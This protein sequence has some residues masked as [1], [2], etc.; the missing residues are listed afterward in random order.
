MGREWTEEQRERQRQLIR[1]VKPWSHS[2]GPRSH[3]GKEKSKYNARKH[4]ER[5]GV[6]RTWKQIRRS[7]AINTLS[8]PEL[9][10]AFKDS[11]TF[12]KAMIENPDLMHRIPKIDE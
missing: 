5:C 1:K 9:Y 10:E 3:F 4:G 11:P 7:M 2:T 12:K 6:R 8:D